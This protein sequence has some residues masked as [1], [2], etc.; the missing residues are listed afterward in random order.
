MKP[1]PKNVEKHLYDLHLLKESKPYQ[2]KALLE[3]S[4]DS[5]VQAICQCCDQALKG[6]V[7]LNGTQFRQVKRH[8]SHIRK[9]AGRNLNTKA[10]RKILTQ[11]GGLAPLLPILGSLIT[12]LIKGLF[13]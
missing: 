10:K 5:L 7:P 11:K 4:T 2:Q 6:R 12:P 8:R 3:A 1:L 9:L 13:S